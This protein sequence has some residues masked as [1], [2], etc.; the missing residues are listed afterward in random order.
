MRVGDHL[1]IGDAAAERP[2][3]RAEQ[4]EVGEPSVPVEPPRQE[5]CG[6]GRQRPG[7][8]A[9]YSWPKFPRIPHPSE[10]DSAVAV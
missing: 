3:Q 9:P 6:Q 7:I 2:A 4:G 10:R 1:H 8:M 5:D